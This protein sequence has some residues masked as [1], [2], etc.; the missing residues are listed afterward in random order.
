MR[1]GGGWRGLWTV[2]VIGELIETIARGAGLKNVCEVG[3]RL[4]KSGRGSAGGRAGELA[5][6]LLDVVGSD[7]LDYGQSVITGMRSTTG[8]GDPEKGD[9]FGEAQSTFNGVNE[10]LKSAVPDDG[11]GG[12]GSYAYAD[13]NTRQQLRSE[14]MADADHE[15]HKVLYREAAQITLR[16][17]YLDDQYNF[18]ANTSYV[19]LPL[20][21][22]PR[23]GEAMKLAIEIGALQTALGESYYQMNRLQSEVAQNAAELQQAVGRYSGVADGAELPGAAV[24]FDPP[25]PPPGGGALHGTTSTG[26][27]RPGAAGGIAGP[28]GVSGGID[29]SSGR[30]PGPMLTED[31]AATPGPQSTAAGPPPLP[32]VPPLGS[33]LSPVA[34][35]VTGAAPAAGQLAAAPAERRAKK[36]RPR[37]E[38][39]TDHEDTADDKVPTKAASGDGQ[40][41]RAPV[42]AE[43]DPNSERLHRPVAARLDAD[44]SPRAACRDATAG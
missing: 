41:E 5:E 10:T 11:W 29:P 35:F 38:E 1:F 34:G 42:H 23:Y 44:N 12:S 15:V 4:T 19:T 18:L 40:S 37:D 30:V 21:F 24:H 13:Q 28:S 9:V 32:R 16:R 27:Q 26:S 39:S 31:E 43:R 7:L 6:K 33:L 36:G 3:E 20:Q 25:P 17:R 22:I 8:Q 2:K 14:A